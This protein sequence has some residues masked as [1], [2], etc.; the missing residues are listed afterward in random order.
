MCIAGSHACP[1]LTF[2]SL[3]KMIPR[4]KTERGRSAISNYILTCG[5][6]S[7]MSDWDINQPKLG[8]RGPNI[9]NVQ[10]LPPALIPRDNNG[11]RCQ[12]SFFTSTYL[13][14][15]EGGGHGNPRP[16]LSSS[17]PWM[18]TG[19]ACFQSRPLIIF[20]SRPW[21]ERFPHTVKLSIAQVINVLL[22]WRTLVRVR[23][24]RL[25]L[26]KSSQYTACCF[27]TQ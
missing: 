18:A 19:W 8:Q 23:R 7:L 2:C 5:S 26:E 10:E 21:E 20:S 14:E 3:W 12:L 24:W 9:R 15:R 17:T 11:N 16:P 25:C 4:N 6:S 22:W 13:R 27:S 1:L